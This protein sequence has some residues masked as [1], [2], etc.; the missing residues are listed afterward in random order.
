MLS[1]FLSALVSLGFSSQP[2]VDRLVC[3][4]VDLT[5]TP[6]TAGTA[7]FICQ[8]KIQELEGNGDIFV[9]R[10]A[11]RTESV[12]QAFDTQTAR[13]NCV[14]TPCPYGIRNYT[15]KLVGNIY[16]TIDSDGYINEI[17]VPIS[18]RL[19]LKAGGTLETETRLSDFY[20]I[21]GSHTVSVP[22][23]RQVIQPRSL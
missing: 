22:K 17:F 14:T 18:S 4:A 11:D 8:A 1:L 6:L 9:I 21:S 10:N 13:V 20:Y 7:V 3:G 12:W 2:T 23:F 15:L 19:I 5:D 16:E